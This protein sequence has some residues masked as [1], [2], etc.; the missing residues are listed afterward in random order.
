MQEAQRYMYNMSLI[1]LKHTHEIYKN[2]V[3]KGIFKIFRVVIVWQEDLRGYPGGS[4]VKTP[5]V[6][7]GETGD[8]R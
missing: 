3:V 5:P 8:S 7:A 6:N 1:A 2:K 4:M